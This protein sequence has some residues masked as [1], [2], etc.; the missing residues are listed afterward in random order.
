MRFARL[1][2]CREAVTQIQKFCREAVTQIQ[3][4]EQSKAADGDSA[5]KK[6]PGAQL[7]PV[8]EK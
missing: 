1:R 5:E 6:A 4:S 2:F 8:V 3:K 7:L